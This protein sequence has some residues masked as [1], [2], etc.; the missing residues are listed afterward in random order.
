MMVD[1]AG[2]LDKAV[3]RQISP[4]MTARVSQRDWSQT[5]LGP[6]ES[7][8]PALRST[9]ENILGNGFGLLLWWGPEHCQIYNDAYRPVL[10]TKHPHS[11]GQPARECWPEIWDVIGPLIERPFQGG[12]PSVIDDLEL[13][14]KRYGFAEETHFIVAYSPVFDESVEGGIGGVLATVQETTEQIIGERRMRLLRDLAAIATEAKSVEEECRLA[15]ST[16]GN[17][18]RDVPFALIYLLDRD[19]AFAELKAG[20]GSR[21]QTAPLSIDLHDPKP[22]PLRADVRPGTVELNDLDGEQT[23]IVPIPSSAAHE[24]AGFLVAGVSSK[25]RFDEKYRDFYLLVASQIGSA[26]ASARAYEEERR[27]AEALAEIDRA[28]NAFFSNVSHEFRTPLTLMLG[29]LADLGKSADHAQ[30]PLVDAAYRNSL[31]LLKLVNT[32]LE[33]S[34]LEAGKVEAAFVRTDLTKLTE[35]ICSAFRSAIESAGL[36]FDVDLQPCSDAYVDRSMWEKIVLNLLS[37][38]LKFTLTG[39]VRV[40]LEC[41]DERVTLRVED[42]GAGISA[43]EL[44]HIFER[45]RRVRGTKSRSHEGSGIGLALVKDL[46][47]L[48]GGTVDVSSE[49]DRGTTFVVNLPRGSNHLDAA[50]IVHGETPAERSSDVAEQ[51]LAE[52]DST[53]SRAA[54]ITQNIS[55]AGA[56]R[57]ILLADD[58]G[59]LREYLA[60]LLSSEYD[61]VAVRNGLEALSEARAGRFDVIVSDLMM[62]ELDGI[63]LLKAVRSDSSLSTTPFVML[64]AKAGEENAVEGLSH[65]ADDYISKPF[66]ADELLARLR[67]NLEAAAVREKA[68]QISE[69]RFHEFADRLPIMVWQ[70]NA[71]GAVIFTNAAWYEITR[72]PRD[73]SSHTAH[74][75]LRVVHPDDYDR[76][77]QIMNDAVTNRRPFSIEYRVKPADGGNDSYRW[78]VASAELQHVQ[79]VFVGWIGYAVDIHDARTRHESERKLLRQ[80]AEQERAFHALAE[81]VPIIVWSANAEGWFDWYNNR[82]FEYTGQTPAEAVGWGWQGVYH[83]H[84][85]QIALQTWLGS[86]ATGERFEMELRIRRHDGVF[87]WFLVRAD[88]LRD[89]S[90]RIVR[91]Y[92]S[93]VDIQAQKDAVEQ[94][95]HVA[96]TLQGVFL[97]NALPRSEAVRFDAVYLAAEK[98]ALIGGDWFD[99]V[100]LP[101]GRFLVSIGDVAGH[102]VDASVIA[103]T[104]RQTI[105]GLAV[106]GHDPA[107]IL[108]N[109]NHIVRFQYADKF[110]TAVVGI[111]DRECT[112]LSYACAGHPPPVLAVTKGVRARSLPHG[113]VPLG[114]Q[115]TLTVTTQEVAIR[116]D[117]VVAFYTDGLTE[118]ARD[119]AAAEKTL[120]DAVAGMVGDVW[121][122]RPAAALQKAVLGDNR[123]IDDVAILIAQFSSVDVDRLPLDSSRLVKEWRF[124]SSDALTATTS[125][126]ELMRFVRHLATDPEAVFTVELILGE[127]LANTV[128]HAPGLVDVRIDWTGEKPLVTIRDTGPGL[129]EFVGRL[130]SDE[131]DEGGRGLFLIRALAQSV[132]ISP[133]VGYGMELNVVLPVARRT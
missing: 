74:A 105:T 19:S 72:L 68:S 49:I 3:L 77:L 10:G 43:S 83:P 40:A 44:P 85:L 104:I 42:T 132:S 64:S 7:W 29:P 118:F 133:A 82:W 55:P 20:A 123:P 24:R 22:W 75:W 66:S 100:R 112:T 1:R 58:N 4:E 131:L 106:S 91:W 61:V 50:S 62:P 15:G 115:D 126:N 18:A 92:G 79:N 9:V 14:P 25:H 107:A 52:V 113:G 76:M 48:Q 17:Y 114:V 27:R 78:Y 73:P 108:E 45:F 67:A 31:R 46:V 94:S 59:D 80:A 70:Q 93:S 65:G 63:E 28:K 57:R 30:K 11:L 111:I 38:A 12:L 47:E 128:E 87:H 117:A 120:Q 13:E 110:A 21:M 95:K 71:S 37:N 101:D 98:D 51:Y 32:L 8:S 33:F 6:V 97:P 41:T 116:R 90:G 16:I 34:R 122:A 35:E 69:D 23:V 125:R 2:F 39:E 99:A 84:D 53:I 88:S 119:I 127:I 124:H 121:T 89:E 81:A 129:R 26:I 109:V 86:I 96:E 102:G 56:R 54:A 36:K 130:P 103:G 5:P 60:R